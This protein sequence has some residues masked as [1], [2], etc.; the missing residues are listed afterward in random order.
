MDEKLQDKVTDFESQIKQQSEELKK[1][2]ELESQIKQNQQ[3]IQQNQ[4]G[5]K[6]AH[7]MKEEITK[8]TDVK[9][10]RASEEA[11]NDFVKEQVFTRKR[12]L[13]LMGV[14]EEEED[15][16]ER[17]KVMG[18]LKTRLKINNPGLSA[19]YRMGARG[20][21]SP[22]PF[23]LTFYSVPQRNAVWYSKASINKDQ[24]LKLWV[25]DDLPRE[26]RSEINALLK[27]YRYAKTI[28]GEFPNIK[29]KDF[30]LQVKGQFYR[31]T[32]LEALPYSIRPSTIATPFS[33]DTVAFFGRDS[34]LSNHHLC[35]FEIEGTPFTTVEQ[36][37]AW[38][39][40]KLAQKSGLAAQILNT[41][42]PAEHK[43][44]LNALKGENEEKWDEIRG[45]VIKTAIRAKFGQNPFLQDFLCRN[46]P[47]KLG[48]ASPNPIW[49]IGMTLR[50]QQ[51]LDQ[52]KWNEEGNLLGKTLELVREELTKDQL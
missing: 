49:G 44:T 4:Q 29:I 24:D 43:R 47:R 21:K 31:S 11:R 8:S 38:R 18:L 3:M 46:F 45:E 17:T 10:K 33:D 14:P 37:L 16:S 1:F 6:A 42:D 25:Q 30:K 23:M 22:R 34:P 52:S 7:G 36:Y 28:Q 48:E 9:I 41:S 32:E 40:A 26:I 15:G 2:K 35:S 39:K 13:L 12:N 50:D 5:I 27:V 19:V 51:V 20:G